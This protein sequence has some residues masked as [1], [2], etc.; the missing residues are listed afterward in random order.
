MPDLIPI[1]DAIDSASRHTRRRPRSLLVGISGID[2]SGK[3]YLSAQLAGELRSRDLRVALINVDGW[4]NLPQ[5]RFEGSDPG[6]CFYEQALRLDAMFEQLV[7]PLRDGGSIDV[8]MDF[9]EET[10]RTFER[11]RVAFSKIDVV[12]LEG[13][14]LFKCAYREHFDLR[15]WI[16]CSFETALARAVARQQEALLPDETI[17]AYRTIYF[18]AQEIHFAQDDP[19]SCA[20]YVVINDPRLT[21]A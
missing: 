4:L 5:H 21:S 16:D 14:F 10:A 2:A 20:E 9:V 15:I 3:G 12:L 6:L 1:L 13:I 8:E 19:R 18:P 17:R 7:L 11:R